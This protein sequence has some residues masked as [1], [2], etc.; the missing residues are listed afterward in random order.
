MYATYGTDLNLAWTES[1]QATCCCYMS[2]CDYTYYEDYYRSIIMFSGQRHPKFLFR[3]T[4]LSSKVSTKL[5]NIHHI[6]NLL[7]E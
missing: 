1:L 6:I 2:P 5:P 3:L 7:G 4:F